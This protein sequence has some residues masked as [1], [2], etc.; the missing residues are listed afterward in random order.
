MGC[1]YGGVSQYRLLAGRDTPFLI[2]LLF[3]RIFF[4]KIRGFEVAR[5]FEGKDIMIPARKTGCSAGYDLEAASQCVL[6]PMEVVLVPTGLKAYMQP[7]EYLGLHVRSGIS[8]KHK[9]ACINSQ[10]IIDADY[11]SNVDNDGHIMVPLINFGKE[12]FVIEKGTRVAQGIFY[13]YLTVDG[14][15]AGKGVQRTGGLGS[16]GV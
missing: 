13:K 9:I 8:V 3:E 2:C 4:M 14:D 5:G 16:T 1:S 7:D 12:A 10:G 6:E 15:E 11:Y